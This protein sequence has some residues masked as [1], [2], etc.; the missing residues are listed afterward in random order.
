MEPDEWKAT[1]IKPFPTSHPLV[2]PPDVLIPAVP[3]N[4][5]PTSNGEIQFSGNKMS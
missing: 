2:G 4:P 1:K 5:I 3:K